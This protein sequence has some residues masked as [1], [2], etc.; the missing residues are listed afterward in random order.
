MWHWDVEQGLA[1][2]AM[3]VW[4]GTVAIFTRSTVPGAIA[5]TL[6]NAAAFVSYRLGETD[7]P[8]APLSLAVTGA[9]LVASAIGARTLAR[10]ASSRPAS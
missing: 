1:A 9:V 8:P 4:L 3:G 7:T 10:R 6:N 5:H 2:F